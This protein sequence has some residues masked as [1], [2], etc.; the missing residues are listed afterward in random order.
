MA[1]PSRATDVYVD[2][3]FT[4]PTCRADATGALDRQRAYRGARLR[5]RRRSTA[6]ATGPQANVTVDASEGPPETLPGKTRIGKATPGKRGG[7]LTAKIAWQPPSA[8]A[9][10]AINGYQVIAYRKNKKGK[11]VKFSTSPVLARGR[12]LDRV[13]DEPS[14][15]AQVRGEGAQRARLRRAQREVERRPTAVGL[16]PRVGACSR[17][18]PWPDRPA[19]GR[20]AGGLDPDRCALGCHR[21][22]RP[23]GRRP[24]ARHPAR[25]GQR[26]R[27]RRDPRPVAGSH[28]SGSPTRAV[29]TSSTRPRRPASAGPRRSGPEPSRRCPRPS[30]CT[31]TPGRGARSTSTS[32]APAS[33]AP[34]GTT[35]SASAAATTAVGTRATTAR[36][37][38]A[39][40]AAVRAEPVGAGGRG[41][42]AVRGRRHHQ[43]PREDRI[44][45]STKRDKVFGTRVLIT[46]AATRTRPSA[47]DS[48]AASRSS[49]CSRSAGRPHRRHQ[50]AWVFPAGLGNDLK[51]IAE[52][53][54]HEAGHTFGLVHD[55]GCC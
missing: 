1:P 2:G 3:G 4:R 51:A 9:N 39:A 52:A 14:A 20:C 13:H 19:P 37:F 55:G 54:T 12:S 15:A 40:G 43:E 46:E 47:T 32:T 30:G 50:P 24:R 41:L 16:P 5:C 34:P 33:G 11:F 6:R 25:R 38:S 44:H 27:A 29:R 48:A 53:A 26:A 7:K 49:T 23:A 22:H 45:R 31:A 35:R 42:R 17:S 18:H 28:W 8:S 21:Q 36:K 10:P